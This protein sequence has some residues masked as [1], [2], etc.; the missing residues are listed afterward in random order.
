MSDSSY[1][2]YIIHTPVIILVALALRHVTLYPLLK[3]AMVTLVAVPTCFLL[4]NVI[5]KLPLAK[6]IL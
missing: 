5:R 2:V 4:A 3:F 1:T 6:K